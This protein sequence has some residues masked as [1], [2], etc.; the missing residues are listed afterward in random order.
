[1]GLTTEEQKLVE[2]F[3]TQVVE[4]S[5]SGIVVLDFWA[6]WCGPCKALTPVIEKACAEYADKGVTLVKINVDENKFIASQFQVQ[7]IPTVYALF[8]GQPVADM[9]QARTESQIKSILDQLLEK[10]PL[11]ANTETDQAQ[12]IAPLLEMGEEVLAA[13]DAQRAFGIFGQITDMAPDNMEAISGLI[14]ALIAGGKVEEAQ[15]MLDELPEDKTGDAALDR[16][17]SAL[18]LAKEAP[19]SGEAAKLKAQVDA[20]PDD[21][22]K[23]LEYAGA[24]FAEQQRDA[25]AD[26]LLTIIR[27]DKDWNEGAARAKLLQIFESVGLEDPWVAA[28]RRKLSAALFG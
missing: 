18:A 27:A 12:D 9:T 4:P 26:E 15:A 14:R 23:R 5:M 10:L 21:H 8:Q 19:T 20:N 11:G 17:K 1:M 13:G 28:T 24:L 3:R 2:E 22:E 25:A 16:A 7:S 6:E